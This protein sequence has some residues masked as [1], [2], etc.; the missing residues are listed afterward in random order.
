MHSNWKSWLQEGISDSQKAFNAKLVTFV[1]GYLH[2]RTKMLAHFSDLIDFGL[3]LR[4]EKDP[5][6][7]RFL[8][9][10]NDLLR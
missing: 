8:E 1:A 4:K 7:K 3:N 10:L 6:K 9:A 5:L 2:Q